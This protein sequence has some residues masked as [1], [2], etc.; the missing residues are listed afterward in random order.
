MDAWYGDIGIALEDGKLVMQF[1]HT[2]SLVGDMEPWQQDTFVVRWRDRETRADA[3]VT[4]AL[5]PDG[6]VE[7]AKIRAVSPETDFS[8][9]F[10]DLLLKPA[11]KP[12]A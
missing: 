2:P 12:A 8:F 3:F 6:N 10:Q 5:D 4:F 1:G 11:R 9:D 7:Q